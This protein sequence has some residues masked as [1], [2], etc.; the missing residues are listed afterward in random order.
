MSGN[1]RAGF[2]SADITP[3]GGPISLTGQWEARVTEEIR[4][5]LMACAMVIQSDSART[6][7]VACDLAVIVKSFSDEVKRLLRASL[8]GFEDSQLILSATHIH[9]GPEPTMDSPEFIPVETE[10]SGSLKNAI[11]PDECCRQA[12]LGVEQAVLNAASSLAPS[13]FEAAVSY[14]ITGVSRRVAY[15]DGTGQMYG[16]LHTPQLAGMEG[17]DGG[18]MQMIYVRRMS[19]SRLTGIIAAVPCPAQADEMA[20]YV[21]A[22]YWATVREVIKKEWG[23]GVVVLGLSRSAG[24]LSPHTMIDDGK[25]INKMYGEDG[26]AIMGRRVGK[27]VVRAADEAVALYGQD[28]AYKHIC[29]YESLPLWSVTRDEYEDAKAYLANA[30]KGG[31]GTL[32]EMTAYATAEV[33]VKNYERAPNECS[34]NFHAVR[35]GDIALITNP[36]E[37]FIEYADRIRMACPEAQV[38]DVQLAGDDYLGYLPTQR[39]INAGGYSAQIYA[40]SCDAKGGDMVVEKSTA[41]IKS[42]FE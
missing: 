34:A 33:R 24:D 15:K 11:P 35:I 38:I 14:T 8:P 26:A 29:A 42:L 9:T 36:F 19:D 32:E 39:A 12:A 17:R 22:D 37:L 23:E 27:A 6:I 5:P 21:T 31:A 40:C 16:A 3:R 20:R 1:A 25:L 28:A 30:A 18:P 4:N 2:G 41:L 7:W 13:C 10:N